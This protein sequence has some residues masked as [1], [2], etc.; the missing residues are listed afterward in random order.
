MWFD[1][2]QEFFKTLSTTRKLIFVCT[3]TFILSLVIG[4]SRVTYIFGNSYQNFT[5]GYLYSLVT[6]VFLHANV[7]HLLV[8][9]Y[10]LENLGSVIE[11]YWSGYKMFIIFIITGTIASFVSLLPAILYTWGI[12]IPGAER[13]AVMSVGASGA[14][15]GLL[16]YLAYMKYDE[17][18]T[19]MKGIS[20][21]V[22]SKMLLL[23]VILNLTIGLSVSSV[24]NYAH[25]GGL[26]AGIAMAYWDNRN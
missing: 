19:L 16:G 17:R 12:V 9:M 18:R 5:E 6:S 25:V 15:F 14:I 26:L 4:F 22:D 11:Y 1:S 21:S 3:A 24:D 20:L 13:V 23:V 10:S 7:I 2:V 8:N